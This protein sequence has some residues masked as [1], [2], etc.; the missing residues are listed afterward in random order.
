[1]PS[2]Q[3][4]KTLVI[5]AGDAAYAYPML[6]SARSVR[7]HATDPSFDIW[8]FAA[9]YTPEQFDA[10]AA[11]AETIRVKVVPM[12]SKDYIR[13]DLARYRTDRDFAHLKPSV[14]SRLVTGQAIPE[15]YDQVLYLDGDTFCTG[16]LSP[17][18]NFD[19][20]PRRLLA[21]AD[22]VNYFKYDTG[23]YATEYRA[24]M[25]QIGVDVDSTWYNTGV[26]MADRATW[27][28]RGAAAL[29]FFVENIDICKFPVD[30]STNATAK[31][32][33]APISSRWNF[34]APMRMW[35]CD[36]EINPAFYHFTG[37]EKPWLGEM[38]PWR[39]FWPR[40]E[41]IRQERPIGAL[42]GPLAKPADIAAANRHRALGRLTESTVHCLRTARARRAMLDSEK[43][44]IV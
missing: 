24:F 12:A 19:V 2:P 6:V 22:A 18:V 29:S 14:L 33:W 41:A 15:E 9:D 4:R 25:R 17:L 43:N 10:A 7:E 42:A 32:H 23:P 20:P 44:A 8:I 30:G 40:Y 26:M 27:A 5:Y 13:F 16:D 11:I 1:M 3:R 21:V 34:M 28:E 36:A 31:D 35:G 38:S 37:K 39:D